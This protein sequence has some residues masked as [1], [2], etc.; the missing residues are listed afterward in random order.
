VVWLRLLLLVSV[1]K[2]RG[3]YALAVRNAVEEYPFGCAE[4][5]CMLGNQRCGLRCILMP[6]VADGGRC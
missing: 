2:E 4:M 6:V 3:K 1:E 5:E